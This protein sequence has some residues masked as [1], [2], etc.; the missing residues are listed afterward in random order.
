MRSIIERKP[1]RKMRKGDENDYKSVINKLVKENRRL[2]TEH[3][4]QIYSRDIKESLKQ[5][6]SISG[7]FWKKRNSSSKGNTRYNNPTNAVRST[8]KNKLKNNY[9]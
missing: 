5:E 3:V 8:S 2:Q 1:S 7:M 4:R 9:F 6:L